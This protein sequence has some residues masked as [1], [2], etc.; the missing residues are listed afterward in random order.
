M[1]GTGYLRRQPGRWE[2]ER[3]TFEVARARLDL[4]GNTGRDLM[5]D[6][7]LDAPDLSSLRDG[8]GGSLEATLKARAAARSRAG[9]AALLVDAAFKGRNLRY[10]EHRAA[11]LSGDAVLDLSDREPSWVRLRAAGIT[12]AGQDLAATRLA[13]DGYAREHRFELQVGAGERAVDLSGT[14]AWQ[15][16]TYGLLANH[17]TTADPT[18]KPYALEAPLRL[19]IS[20]DAARLYETCFV[21]APRRVCI[22]GRW[23]EGTGWSATLATR[24]FPL[25]QVSVTLPGRPGYRGQ[26]DVTLEAEGKPDRPWTARGSASLHDAWLRYRAASGRDEE[27]SLGITEIR[28][29]ST[30]DAHRITLAQRASNAVQLDAQA[31]IRRID[32]RPLS[33]SPLAGSLSLSTTH[34][35]LLP[36][37]VPDIDRAVGRLTADV[38]LAGTPAA[39]LARGRLELGDCALDYYQTNLRMTAVRARVDLLDDGFQLDASGRIGEGTFKAGGRVAWRERVMR[40]ELRF[41]G[42]RL[43]VADVPEATIEASPDLRFVIDGHRINVAGNVIVPSARIE[44][45]QLVGVV[46]PSTDELLAGAD[47]PPPSGAAYRVSTDVRLALGADVRLNAFGLKG[48]LEGGLRLLAPPDEVATASGE[49]EIDDGKYRAYGRDLEVERGRLLFAG[50]PAADP[51]VDLRASKTVPGYKVGVIARGRLRK[52]QLTLYSDP[53]LPQTQIASLLLVGQT[54]DSLQSRDRQSL[55]SSR[56]DFLTQG[57]GVLVG[58]LGRYIGLDEVSVQT[59]VDDDASLVLGKFLSSRLYVSYGISLT[60]AIN[61][62][63]LRY[64]IGDRWVLTGESGEAASADVL[65][66]IER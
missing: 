31:S 1:S 46:Q 56:S 20:R 41:A 7:R 2:F 3:F 65:Y 64:T 47:G 35:G 43:R 10:G 48:R 53:S 6:A 44:P 40:G 32:G 55:G 66:T 38:S 57:G 18:L 21:A 36:L 63:K 37:F 39:P 49:L 27:L 28:A 22:D 50:G 9:A 54:L 5:L 29:E 33:D 16:G 59:D 14:G 42:E 19:D 23:R 52:P 26:L 13:L 12:L 24:S 17:I 34:L 11:V 30:E 51:G 8:L 62:F 58:Q 4:R 60:E 15:E 25:E 45:R 61:T